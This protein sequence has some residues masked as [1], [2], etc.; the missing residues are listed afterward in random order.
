MNTLA[1]IALCL[2][3]FIIIVAFLFVAILCWAYYALSN[4][5]IAFTSWEDDEEITT[6]K[7]CL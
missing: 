4:F 2:L 7:D 3:A 1:V 6:S 5:F